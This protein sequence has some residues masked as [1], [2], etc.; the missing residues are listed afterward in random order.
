MNAEAADPAKRRFAAFIYE[1]RQLVVI[2]EAFSAQYSKTVTLSDGTVRTIELTAMTGDDNP[3][4]DSKIPAIA[5]T[6][7]PS[8][9]A[10][11]RT[12]TETSWFR[13]LTWESGRHHRRCRGTRR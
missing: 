1:I 8:A 9:C 7:A 6:A 5:P 3:V 2:A 11:D 4:I 12:P 13:S 10:P